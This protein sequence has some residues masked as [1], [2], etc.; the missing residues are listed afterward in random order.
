MAVKAPTPIPVPCVPVVLAV[1][2]SNPTA[3]LLSPKFAASA[4]L[5]TAVLAVPVLFAFKESN[6]TAVLFA[7]V[8]FA[9]KASAPPAVFPAP[10]V[11]IPLYILIS[12]TLESTERSC[13]NS[14]NTFATFDAQ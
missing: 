6:P 9:A 4:S 10:V 11:L 14:V 12:S 7:A 8:V 1:M 5:P 3:V 2:A 13:G